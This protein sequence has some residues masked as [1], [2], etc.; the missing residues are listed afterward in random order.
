MYYRFCWLL[1]S[2]W[3]LVAPVAA[4]PPIPTAYLFVYFTGNSQAEEAIRYALS[5]DGFRYVAL[6]GDQPVISSAIISETGGVRDPHLLRGVDGH[7]YYLV[8]TDMV[9]AK[10]WNSNRGMVLLKSTDLMHW[11]SKAINF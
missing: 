3:W 4:K 1:A 5:A 6:N 10:G 7:I 2:F 9:S 11:T 8:A